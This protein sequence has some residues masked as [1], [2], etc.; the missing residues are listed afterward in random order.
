MYY[1]ITILFKFFL[2]ALRAYKDL[3]NKLPDT[4]VIYRDGFIRGV[5]RE[6]IDEQESYVYQ[7]EVAMVKVSISFFFKY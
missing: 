6:E 1:S 2:G 4:I 7:K 5:T 3:N